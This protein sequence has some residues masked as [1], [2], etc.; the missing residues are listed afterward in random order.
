MDISDFKI[1]L[2]SLQHDAERVPPIGL[3]YLATYLEDRVGLKKENI[4]VYDNNYFS[5]IEDQIQDFTPHVV[6]ISA[7]TVN[8]EDAVRFCQSFKNRPESYII[9]TVPLGLLRM[10]KRLAGNAN[11]SLFTHHL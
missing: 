11:Q 6:G 9:S 1:A 10:C 5:N 7:M 8:Y 2:V 3:I 4:K